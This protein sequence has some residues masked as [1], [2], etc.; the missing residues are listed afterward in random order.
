MCGQ[1]QKESPLLAMLLAAPQVASLMETFRVQEKTKEKVCAQEKGMGMSKE[2]G[3]GTD[4]LEEA[5]TLDEVL[6]W[7]SAG[8]L[9]SL[10]PGTP[11]SRLHP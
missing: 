8:G 3:Q 9:H 10:T 1:G 7:H 2:G 4:A 11:S 5:A 6:P